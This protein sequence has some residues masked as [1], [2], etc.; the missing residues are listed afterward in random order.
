MRVFLMVI[1]GF[2][3]GEMPDAALFGDEGSDTY[4]HV[5]AATR[6]R[7]PHLA[8]LGLN[9]ICGIGPAAAQFRVPAPN[10]A[11]GRMSEKTFA[12][13]TTAG[14]YELAG[15]VMQKPFRV[16]PNGFPE[17]IVRDL[18]KATGVQFMGNEVASGTE[19]IQRLGEEHL[20][21]GKIILYTSQD[22]VMQIA[23]DTSVLP[24]TKLYEVCEAARAVM[25][26]ERTVGRVI[27]RPFF[28]DECGHF[29]RTKDR[30]DYSLEPPGQTLLDRLAAANIP[31]IGVGKIGDI[32]C[33]RGIARSFH[34]GSNSEG[35]DLLARLI[36]DT[37]EGLV[38]VNLVETDMLFGH[39]NDVR[40]YSKALRLID[41][42]LAT[43]KRQLR[44]E[45]I[46]I[47]TADH[48]C[49]PTTPSTDHS[50]EYVPLLI[51]GKQ[52]SPCDLGT[53]EGFDNVARF[54][55]SAFGLDDGY[56][57]YKI[58]MRR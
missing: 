41:S 46:L 25:T 32:F 24:L 53:L 37:E 29:R 20:R 54:I 23:S 11:Y 28:H 50:R 8:A 18:E 26:G 36:G 33:E 48:G 51:C 56:K 5:V 42:R 22:S 52:V 45:D 19:I 15:L 30:K 17:D 14:H 38:F 16:F 9:N 55:A 44:K 7:L 10:A 12:K 35:L 6:I 43:L 21:T 4:G 13:D 58:V 40:G 2:G 31:V 49:D 27:A 3:I 1:D 47:I 57:L 34:T 39:R